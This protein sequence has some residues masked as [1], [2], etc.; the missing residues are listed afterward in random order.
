MEAPPGAE[1]VLEAET[2][3]GETETAGAAAGS[4]EIRE[5]GTGGGA[6]VTEP[7]AI[8]IAAWEAACISVGCPLIAASAASEVRRKAIWASAMVR[9]YAECASAVWRWISAKARSQSGS[10]VFESASTAM[11]SPR[12][13]GVARGWGPPSFGNTA[14]IPGPRGGLG[15]GRDSEPPCG[16]YGFA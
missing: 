6:R 15:F 16:G 5:G 11:R 9:W 14:G 12:G 10:G 13:V 1:G 8:G 4:G 7:D 2:H 3:G